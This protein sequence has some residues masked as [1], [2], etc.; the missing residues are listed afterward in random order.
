MNWINLYLP[1]LR[2][3][4]FGCADNEQLGIWLRLATYCFDQENGGKVRGAHDW[5]SRKCQHL[6]TLDRAD[7]DK[8]SELWAWKGK[9]LVLHYFPKDKQKLVQDKRQQASEAAHARWE[10]ARGAKGASASADAHAD[11]HADALRPALRKGKDKDKE[12]DKKK[13]KG[14]AAPAAAAFIHPSLSEV[15]S[16]FAEQNAPAELATEFFNNYQANGWVQASGVAI[17]DW[18]A[19]GRKWVDTWRA[20]GAKKSPGEFA[21][22]DGYDAAQPHAA[23]GGIEVAN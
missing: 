16:F 4:A 8:K 22:P 7:L 12:K 10:K 5:A 9:D 20:E 21:P 23:T 13:G 17:A 1:V 14:K 19:Q 6:L 15:I 3:E 11:A 2:N 18:R